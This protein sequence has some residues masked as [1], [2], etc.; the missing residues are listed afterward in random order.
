M[1]YVLQNTEIV[2]PEFGIFST[3]TALKRPNFANRMYFDG[4]VAV[5]R[6]NNIICGTKIDLTRAVSLVEQD[7]S[8]GLLVDTLNR[9]MLHGSMSLQVRAHILD[10][11]GAVA[12]GN[13][14]KRAQTA[15]YLVTTSP[16]F[17]VQR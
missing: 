10:A 11:V 3:G 1:D 2:A 16:Q 6:Q 12:A 15:L 5:N 7:A 8:G 14:L 4:G 13:K 9:E 17:Q